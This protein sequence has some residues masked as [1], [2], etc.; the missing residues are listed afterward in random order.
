VDVVHPPFVV[1]LVVVVVAAS[2][3]EVLFADC[4]SDAQ[5]VL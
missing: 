3:E 1:R 2:G 5:E 4:A